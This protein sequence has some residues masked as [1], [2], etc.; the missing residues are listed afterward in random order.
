MVLALGSRETLH[1]NGSTSQGPIDMND[2]SSYF[3]TALH[4]FHNFYDHPQDLFR[5]QAILLLTIWMLDSPISADIND[6][7]HLARYAMSAVIEAGLHR[8]NTDWGFTAEELEIR[9]RAWWSAYCLERYF[10][11][12]QGWSWQLFNTRA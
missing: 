11:R 8:H 9:N 2:S 12:P 6:L 5:I 3:Q 10:P 4:F 7:W 1:G